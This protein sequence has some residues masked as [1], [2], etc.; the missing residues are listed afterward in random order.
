MYI[1]YDMMY[2]YI[3]IGY[4]MMIIDISIDILNHKKIGIH[5]KLGTR[6]NNACQSVIGT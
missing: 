4:D 5:K 6:N 2:V 1:G 3:C